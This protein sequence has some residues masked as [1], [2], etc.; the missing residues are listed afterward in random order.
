MD[1]PTHRRTFLFRMFCENKRRIEGKSL[2]VVDSGLILSRALGLSVQNSKMSVMP[3][4][5]KCSL[6][7]MV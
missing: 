1:S 2:F 3:V 5:T 4:L 6:L 7:E